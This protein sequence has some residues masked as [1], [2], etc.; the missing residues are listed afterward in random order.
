MLYYDIMKTALK[1]ILDMD[2]PDYNM[3]EDDMYLYYTVTAMLADKEGD[4]DKAN[5]YYEKVQ[6]FWYSIHAK[7]NYILPKVVEEEAIFYKKTGNEE[8][9][10]K[11]LTDT[12]KFC[13][14]NLLI[15]NAEIL[16]LY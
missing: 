14:K 9:R 16:R 15:H 4:Y 8:S 7:Q 6:N 1:H 13:K 11:V 5:E 3:W 10:K 12:I 2:N